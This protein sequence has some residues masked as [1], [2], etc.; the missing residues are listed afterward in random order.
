MQQI[1]RSG[2]C[3][4][5]GHSNSPLGSSTARW[6]QPRGPTAQ[7]HS[8]WAADPERQRERQGC[9]YRAAG[10]DLQ[11]K[12]R[13]INIYNDSRK[14]VNCPFIFKGH[15]YQ[16]GRGIVAEV[17]RASLKIM[18]WVVSKGQV[19]HWFSLYGKDSNMDPQNFSFAYSDLM[20]ISWNVHWNLRSLWRASTMN[21][22]EIICTLRTFSKG[23]LN[24]C[25]V[26]ACARGTFK[27]GIMH[28][29]CAL[30]WRCL[31]RN[32][33]KCKTSFHVT[34]INTHPSSAVKIWMRCSIFL[35]TD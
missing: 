4:S 1:L 14:G 29:S 8:S 2:L 9:V 13:K 25:P 34:Q 32:P 12:I 23:W 20:K 22:T 30:S 6:L 24:S 21:F 19:W 11:R 5:A 35:N 27:Y 17:C 15:K 28:W 33:G 31:N 10:D 26:P 16:G 7:R 3:S 18:G